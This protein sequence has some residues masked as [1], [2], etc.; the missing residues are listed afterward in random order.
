LLEEFEW[1]H[2]SR[3]STAG[4]DKELI[5][6]NP[7]E[8]MVITPERYLETPNAVLCGVITML[9]KRTGE[10]QPRD[11]P[12]PEPLQPTGTDGGGVRP[13]EILL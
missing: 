10:N 12:A 7:Y 4:R 8:P 9:P 6:L 5:T 1:I 11:I 2:R 13:G 3:E